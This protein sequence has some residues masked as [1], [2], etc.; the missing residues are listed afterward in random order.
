MGDRKDGK[1]SPSS[2]PLPGA[3][4][5]ESRSCPLREG[6]A[7]APA[8]RPP[9]RRSRGSGPDRDRRGRAVERRTPGF[10]GSREPRTHRRPTRASPAPPPLVPDGHT[11]RGCLARRP[12]AAGGPSPDQ[13]PAHRVPAFVRRAPCPGRGARR[14]LRPRPARYP[15]EE[16]SHLLACPVRLHSR[17]SSP[18]QP[19]RRAAYDPLAAAAESQAR[20][21]KRTCVRAQGARVGRTV[22]ARGARTRRSRVCL[23]RGPRPRRGTWSKH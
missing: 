19:L 9:E 17:P 18:P 10:P 5:V 3:T 16:W 21:G 22:R 11:Q 6:P 12:P 4:Q 2:A 14:P 1:G 20:E 23:L 15:G 8:P 7:S 13:W